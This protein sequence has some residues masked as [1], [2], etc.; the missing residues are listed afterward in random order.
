MLFC[1]DTFYTTRFLE[2]RY[3]I[4]PIVDWLRED[5]I[6]YFGQKGLKWRDRIDLNSACLLLLTACCP[7]V[8][9]KPNWDD[10]R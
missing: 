10:S 1:S 5:R 2:N 6:G 4:A 8:I 7:E 9:P 3:S